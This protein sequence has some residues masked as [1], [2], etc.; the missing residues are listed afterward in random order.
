MYII[1]LGGPTIE[2]N[3]PKTYMGHP[4]KNQ[5]DKINFK[6]NADARRPIA[7]CKIQGIRLNN[8]YIGQIEQETHQKK[9]DDKKGFCEP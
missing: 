2:Q 5:I 8:F 9:L 6:G 7:Y 4:K 1:V 3:I